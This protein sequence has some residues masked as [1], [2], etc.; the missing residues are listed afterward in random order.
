MARFDKYVQPNGKKIIDI[1]E[2]QNLSRAALAKKA[3]LSA[4]AVRDIEAGERCLESSLFAIATA[5]GI[6]FKSIIRQNEG[7]E[8]QD[9]NLRDV[10]IEKP[11]DFHAA[12]LN[13]DIKSFVAN[14]QKL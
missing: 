4:K 6:K 9:P 2:G 12:D 3:D 14:L 1:R 7:D 5:L 8:K 10:D 11:G 13:D